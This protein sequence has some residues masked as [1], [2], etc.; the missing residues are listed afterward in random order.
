MFDL[1]DT[2]GYWADVENYKEIESE[3]F[4]LEF[5]HEPKTKGIILHISSGGIVLTHFYVPREE[6]GKWYFVT[7]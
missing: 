1:A 3:I 7:V 5:D 6:H 2:I 4:K